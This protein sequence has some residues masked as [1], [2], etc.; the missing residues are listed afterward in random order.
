MGEWI[1]KN[2]FNMPNDNELKSIALKI[3]ENANK[4]IDIDKFIKPI[5]EIV[6]KF[7]NDPWITQEEISKKL[8]LDR[9]ELINLN[10]HIRE[11][12]Y[13]QNLI[14]DLFK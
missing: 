12:N 11:N 10:K 6:F 5:L 8:N 7:A 3:N 13:L 4:D 14:L 1:F 9:N 2:E